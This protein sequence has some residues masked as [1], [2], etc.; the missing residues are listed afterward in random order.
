M[1]MFLAHLL[2]VLIIL[3]LQA[4]ATLTGLT[5]NNVTVPY[6]QE[7]ESAVQHGVVLTDEYE[8]LGW[9]DL[10]NITVYDNG[11][12]LVVEWIYEEPWPLPGDSYYFE[13]NINFALDLDNDVKTGKE[14]V[15][16]GVRLGVFH[17]STAEPGHY[18]LELEFYNSSGNLIN[19][20]LFVD[21]ATNGYGVVI[22]DTFVR[23]HL[24]LSQLNL[25]QE[26]VV[27]LMGWDFIPDSRSVDFIPIEYNEYN[28]SL[29]TLQVVVDGKADE[30]L[31]T[32][33]QLIDPPDNTYVNSWQ[34]GNLTKVKIAANDTHLFMLFTVNDRIPKEIMRSPSSIH[35]KM[36]LDFEPDG[37]VDKGLYI[38]LG[39]GTEEVHIYSRHSEETCGYPTCIVEFSD[40]FIE[41]GIPLSVLGLDKAP[42]TLGIFQIELQ[43]VT[44]DDPCRAPEVWRPFV[45]PLVIYDISYGGYIARVVDEASSRWS[46][47]DVEP[48]YF[49]RF[50]SI[51]S[52]IYA[53]ANYTS[54]YELATIVAYSLEPTGTATLPDGLLPITPFYILRLGDP[55]IVQ[56]P[57]ELTINIST[58]TLDGLDLSKIKLFIFNDT[59][60]KYEEVSQEYWSLER[61]SPDTVVLCISYSEEMYLAGDDPILVVAAPATTLRSLW[62]DDD[63]L[64]HA[65]GEVFYDH[66]LLLI[67][68]LNA[69][70][71]PNLTFV[72]S[73]GTIYIYPGIYTIADYVRMGRTVFNISKPVA[74]VGIWEGGEAPVINTTVVSVEADNV[75]IDSLVLCLEECIVNVT[76]DN[77]AIENS[78]VNGSV[79]LK[80]IN[81]SRISGAR[82]VNTRFTW[83]N[84][85]V[86]VVN[87]SVASITIENNT[88]DSIATNGLPLYVGD[89]GSIDAL[90]ITGNVF[91]GG[92]GADSSGINLVLSN[93]TAGEVVIENNTFENIVDM[94]YG[95]GYGIFIAL[96]RNATL[97]KLL[98]SRNTLRNN[99]Y[100][101]HIH[102]ELGASPG[103]V[104]IKFNNF[105]GNEHCGLE[106]YTAAELVVNASMNWWGDVSGPGG[107]FNGTGDAVY[108]ENA[109]VFVSPWLNAPYPYGAPVYLAGSSSISTVLSPH[110]S[111][112]LDAK[113]VADTEVVAGGSAPV[114]ISV[115]KYANNPVTS[116]LPNALKFVDLALNT[117]T[118]VDEL[119]VKIYYTSSEVAG[120]DERSLKVFW[121]NES[122]GTWV[123]CSAYSINTTDTDGYA[124]YVELVIN[125]TTTPSI[126]DLVGAPLGLAGAP[127]KPV[128]PVVGGYL[129]PP[130]TSDV[131]KVS[132]TVNIIASATLIGALLITTSLLR[133]Q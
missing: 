120:L 40:K 101:V 133:K 108:A 78:V 85:T 80:Y 115:L 88:F 71:A 5:N 91:K 52:T 76:G 21:N 42:N 17:L 83:G 57:I 36:E 89:E 14:G 34:Y 4:P 86:F 107:I 25:T 128:A 9:R 67:M 13:R 6:Y 48:P 84:V 16:L 105:E 65:L 59:S 77:V 129:E 112:V 18:S 75:T 96:N 69:W 119:R 38:I 66:G 113:Q 3:S 7:V 72:E 109:K 62:V 102:A 64:Q 87:T 125:S 94:Y 100:G 28:V 55:N 122:S 29:H 99:S 15:E 39:S 97:N 127:L 92:S 37:Q 23:I 114:R 50:R 10:R 54:K 70:Y 79:G 47:D 106:I 116:P 132:I 12:H 82:I 124:G 111:L 60:K 118:G 45:S 46:T 121:W 31:E 11:T 58:A 104:E 32:D 117:S 22:G 61:P 56:W 74:L 1:R 90:R 41:V 81:M 20:L 2:L 35:I 49:V 26:D 19:T 123:E 126:G 24:P 33:P 130:H 98:I 131:D 30:W 43:L 51:F 93:G 68:G 8:G 73:G 27:R 63:W 103:R 110:P 95:E 44:I 53:E